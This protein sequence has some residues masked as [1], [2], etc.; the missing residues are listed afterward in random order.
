MEDTSMKK[1]PSFTTTNLMRITIKKKKNR[2]RERLFHIHVIHSFGL[3]DL[4]LNSVDI[5]LSELTF[6]LANFISCFQLLLSL[7]F[8]S[9]IAELYETSTYI[10]FL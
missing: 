5:C 9:K 10:K 7:D 1:C 6:H 4:V 3:K 8:I 2:E